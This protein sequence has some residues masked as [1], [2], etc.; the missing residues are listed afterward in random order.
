MTSLN[1]HACLMLSN[2]WGV[3]LSLNLH[4]C[5]MLRNT[6]WLVMTSLNL[7]ACLMLRN[8]WWG[9]MMLRNTWWLVM[10]SL[11]LHACL[12]SRNT[13]WLVMTSLFGETLLRTPRPWHLHT[14]SMLRSIHLSELANT[15]SR[16]RHEYF[17]HV[18]TWSMLRHV[19]LIEIANYTVVHTHMVDSAPSPFSFHL[20]TH[21]RFYA[22]LID[23]SMCT[24]VGCYVFFV[25][26]ELA[27]MQRRCYAMCIVVQQ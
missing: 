22:I 11:N 20:S 1:L 4:A 10:T 9:V 6:W 25:L 8:T 16:L 14:W 15:F 2:T 17:V 24:N 26:T 23:F 7:D 3:M 13:W 27:K 21:K 12:M 19:H 18:H 5:L